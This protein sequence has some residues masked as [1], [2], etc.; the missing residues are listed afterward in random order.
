MTRHRLTRRERK[1]NRVG[2]TVFFVVLLLAI[3]LVLALPQFYISS[4]KV[5]GQRILTADQVILIGDLKTGSHLFQ[6]VSG[7][8]K[9]WFQLRHKKAEELLLSNLPYLK[10]VKIQSVFPSVL[11][12][13]LVERVEVAYIAISDGCVIIDSEGVA[14]EVLPGADARGIPV[15]EG[16]VANQ[17]QLGRKTAVDLPDA[18]TEAIV[19]LNDIINA[20]KDT[21][22]DV[23]LLPL[24]KTIRPMQ[25]KILFLTLQLP[26]TGEELHIKIKNSSSNIEDMLWLRFALKQGKLVG[27]SKGILDLSGVQKVFQPES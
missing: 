13:T 16:V 20:D 24:I 18:L 19:L 6:G 12:V 8:M 10:N 1:A 2:T 25:D 27:K 7:S 3:L 17:V 11:S 4:V 15:I 9:D 14:L 21:Q 5:T 22:T 23:K 26:G